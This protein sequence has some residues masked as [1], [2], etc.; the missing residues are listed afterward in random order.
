MEHEDRNRRGYQQSSVRTVAAIA[1]TLPLLAVTREVFASEQDQMRTRIYEVLDNSGSMRSA[2]RFRRGVRA[3]ERWAQAAELHSG[4][5]VELLVAAD[6]VVPQGTFPLRSE[7]E[8]VILLDRLRELELERAS[9]T[10]FR[11]IDEEL[12]AF[13]ARTA[14][15]DERFGVV[16][17]TDG[18]SDTP[19]T[20]LRL[21]D[22]GDQVLVLGGGLYGAV[23]GV[24]PGQEELL[25][26][27]QGQVPSSRSEPGRSRSRCR[28]LFGSSISITPSVPVSAEVRERLLG[29]FAPVLT[30]IQVENSGEVAREVRLQAQAPEGTG[31]R[32]IPST[33]VVA[34]GAKAEATLDI[35]VASPVSGP[36]IVTAQG[37]DGDPVEATLK[38]E[39]STESWLVSNWMALVVFAATATLLFTVLLRVRR[40]PW[41][42][43]PIGRPD[44][45]FEIRPGEEVP[46]S[47]ADPTFPSGIWIG[48]RR[49]VLWLRTAGEPVRLAGVP[50]QPGRDVPYRLRTPIDAGSASVVLDHRSRRPARVCAPVIE[51]AMEHAA[52]GNDLL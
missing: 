29:G 9:N 17:I 3:L 38:A 15:P 11:R 25:G 48:R 46:L 20:D 42:I 26:A 40:R 37:P 7:R 18:R 28:R 10:V 27:K 51:G 44:R 19:A 36:I 32:F 16:F 21:Q 1:L 5:T 8:R 50:V 13:V 30:T 12:A 6:R 47:M 41:F 33:L 23:S 34:A 35:E 22:L 39:I 4:L 14:H 45:G 2:S 31:V 43:I 24:V 49:G 52:T